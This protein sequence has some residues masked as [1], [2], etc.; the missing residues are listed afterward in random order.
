MQARMMI[1]RRDVA[2]AERL[3]RASLQTS[4][5]AYAVARLLAELLHKRKETKAAC[6]LLAKAAREIG[7]AKNLFD[8]ST[9]AIQSGEIVL[10]AQLLDEAIVK[11]PKNLQARIQLAQLLMSYGDSSRASAVLGPVIQI[12][13][14]N[15]PALEMLASIQV[16]AQ[17]RIVDLSIFHHLLQVSPD[18]K[19]ALRLLAVAE[20]YAGKLDEAVEHSREALDPR[21][22]DSCASHADLLELSGRGEEGL[23]ILEPHGKGSG[24]LQPHVANV[25]A[26]LLVRQK[27]VEEAVGVL[28]RGLRAAN[29]SPASVSSLALQRGSALSK[30]GRSEEA[31]ES[32]T[33]AKLIQAGA[34][35]HEAEV[36]RVERIHAEF[37]RPALEGVV[38]PP[39]SE[40]C[41]VLVL[42]MYRSGTTLMEQIL[43]MHPAIG[44]ADEVPF[45]GRAAASI[46]AT[47]DWRREWN[48][49]K[50]QAFAERYRAL[51]R[52]GNPGK[53][54]VVDKNPRNWE[55]VGLAAL[56]CPDA[57]V[58]HMDR[59]PLDVCVSCM[60]TGFASANIFAAEPKSFAQGFALQVE[61]MEK[62]KADPPLPM[63]TLRYEDLVR[64]PERRIREVLEFIGLPWDPICLDFWKS[65]RIAFTP[66]QDQVREPLNPRSMGRW[67][68]FAQQLE[69]AREHLES[70][71][72]SCADR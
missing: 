31:W 42:G 65:E 62:W 71:G 48:E 38:R 45:F 47:P 30:L 1:Q 63:M 64:E 67:R 32:W 27:R 11:D 2:G 55:T 24:P 43:T 59:H 61:T 23:R 14:Y 46:V 68:K 13:P 22:P 53:P 10:G 17:A 56:V 12:D 28:D 49:E 33:Y 29:V 72:I 9:L 21:D 69:P 51:L 57:V 7:E 6:E 37:T 16:G 19:R 5:R 18:R 26:R 52:H 41:P 66:S 15:L 44:G 40:P 60:A 50:A 58:I 4:P 70:R 8:A 20:R 25:L 3:L 34:Y 36:R 35:V 54:I 39:V